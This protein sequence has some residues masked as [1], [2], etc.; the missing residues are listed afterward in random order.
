MSNY[1]VR[2]HT[3]AMDTASG[4]LGA[5]QGNLETFKSEARAEFNRI[6]AN[7]GDG[8]GPEEVEAVRKKFEEYLDEHVKS[9][10]TSQ[11]GLTNATDTMAQGGRRMAARLANRA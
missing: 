2:A 7:L 1:Q 4:D 11:T 5:H 6:V 9:I 10:K 3:G 8:I